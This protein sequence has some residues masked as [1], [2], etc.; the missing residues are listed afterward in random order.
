MTISEL[1]H[2]RALRVHTPQFLWVLCA[3]ALVF[4]NPA[5]AQQTAGKR[6]LTH[7]DYDNWRSIQSS[8]L[9]RD[10]RFLAYALV[11]QEG[12]GEIV[13]R[14]HSTGTEWRYTRG[15][16]Q[17]PT[18]DETSELAPPPQ[19]GGRGSG[20]ARSNLLAF[21]ADARALVFQIAPAK[22]ENEKTKKVQEVR[23]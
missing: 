19:R 15:S 10:G 2:P 22:A 17:A 18:G 21:T 9:S 4:S 6:A 12:D 11:L 1:L 23:D 20:P 3:L 7:N 5:Q 14:N 8:Q 13:A 16:R